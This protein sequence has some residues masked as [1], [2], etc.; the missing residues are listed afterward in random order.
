MR[1]PISLNEIGTLRRI[2]TD[3]IYEEHLVNFDMSN[4]DDVLRNLSSAQY[5]F[6]LHLLSVKKWIT[7]KQ[8]LS[9]NGLRNK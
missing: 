9:K 4:L 5:R 6:I 1:E 2:L 3:K 7:I 8:I